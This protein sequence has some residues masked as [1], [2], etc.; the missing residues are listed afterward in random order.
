LVAAQRDTDDVDV[1][2]LNR[3]LQSAAPAAAD[4]EQRHPGLEVQLAQRQ[5]E[6]GVLRLF[7]RHV[8]AL[9]VG[10]AVG[11]GLVLKQA[12]E[13]VGEVVMGLDVFRPRLGRSGWLVRHPCHPSC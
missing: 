1:V 6:L 11:P 12:E 3:A 7:Q 13:V 4:V 10:A 5:I 8:V 2:A 9:E